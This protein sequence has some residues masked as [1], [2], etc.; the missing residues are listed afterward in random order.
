MK[1]EIGGGNE[2]KS[3]T[4]DEDAVEFSSSWETVWE[5]Q[6]A[7]PI[8]HMAFSPDGTLFATCGKNDRLVKIWYEHKPG[9]KIFVYKTA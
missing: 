9:N 2:P 8:H 7:T 3:P 1:F 5:C 4:N 6:T